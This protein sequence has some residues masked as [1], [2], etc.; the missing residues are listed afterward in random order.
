MRVVGQCAVD[1]Q[2]HVY[3]IGHDT[4][5]PHFDSRVV[6][7]NLFYFFVEDMFPQRGKD[8]PRFVVAYEISK[9]GLPVC[10]NDSNEIGTRRE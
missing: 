5:F 3:M 8:Y 9:K 4:C 10:H 1:A 7:V 6:L 2:N